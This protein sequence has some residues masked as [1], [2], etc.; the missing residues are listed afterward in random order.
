MYSEANCIGRLKNEMR[1]SD[2]QDSPKAT[3]PIGHVLPA[4]HNITFK[5]LIGIGNRAA[6][7]DSE[8]TL[9]DSDE[10]TTTSQSLCRP[11]RSSPP[12]ELSSA[13][14][15]E[16]YDACPKGKVFRRNGVTLMVY[17]PYL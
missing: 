2:W 10:T 12:A 13:G 5:A 6:D 9:R 15:T 1:R 8:N 17:K 4:E 7:L 11:M 14:R 3:S 16:C